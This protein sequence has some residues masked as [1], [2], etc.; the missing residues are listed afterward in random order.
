MPCAHCVN[1]REFLA[2]T[3]G[4]AAIAAALAACGDGT[5]SGAAAN[6][7][8]PPVVPPGPVTVKIGN[9]PEL[10]T[11]GV[12]VQ[13]TEAFVALKRTGTAPDTFACYSLS[14]THEGC[15]VD[16]VNGQR[17]DCPCHGSR[18]DSNGQVLQGPAQ[19]PLRTVS[20]SY[21]PATDLLT[22]G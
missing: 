9:Y 13:P 19:Q 18:F 22:I 11:V 2:R 1:R 10:A 16:I 14:C 17:F 8:K 20:T 7:I 3:A 12:L 15:A 4:G 6:I 5:I 21:D